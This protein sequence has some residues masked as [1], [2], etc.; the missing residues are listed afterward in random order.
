[1]TDSVARIVFREDKK[2]EQVVFA[3]VLVPDVVNNYG[4]IYTE[5][6]IAEFAYEFARQGYGIDVDH[7]NE[8][9][10][11]T[12]AYVVESFLVRAGDPDFIKGSWVIGVKVV[13]EELWE[14]ILSGSIN[15]FSYEAMV[16]MVPVTFTGVS[17][18]QVSG[19][20]SEDPSDGHSHTYVVFLDAFNNPISGATSENADHSHTIVSHTTTEVVNGHNHRYQVVSSNHEE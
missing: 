16:T 4:D 7:D 10:N 20:T 1:M 19:T 3:E 17:G 14:G 6:A 13:D 12:G 15:G 5:E 9:I 11:G 18:R 2:W 8:D